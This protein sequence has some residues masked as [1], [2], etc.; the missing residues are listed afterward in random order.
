MHFTIRYREACALHISGHFPFPCRIRG[1]YAI[2]HYGEV[3][4]IPLVRTQVKKGM[5]KNYGSNV[6]SEYSGPR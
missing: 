2:L 5:R 3:R 4:R 6:E 1:K